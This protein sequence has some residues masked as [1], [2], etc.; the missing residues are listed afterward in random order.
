[1]LD[2]VAGLGDSHWGYHPLLK[3][4]ESKLYPKGL[5]PNAFD[6]SV[7]KLN[8]G[9]VVTLGE[10]VSQS[11][12]II[13]RGTCVSKATLDSEDVIVKWSW[14]AKTRM[15][16]A[17]LVKRATEFASRLD[18]SLVLNHLP[19]LLHCEEREF[20]DDSPQQYLSHHF[21]EGY[22]LRVLRIVVQEKLYPITDLTTAAEPGEAFRGIFRCYRWLY[23]KADIM[24]RDI[25]LN[26]LMYRRINGKVYG[27]LN[28][29]DLSVVM[30]TEPLSTSK[31]RTGTEPY[32]ARDLL[33]IGTPP[34]H[35]YRF[36]LESLFY[37]MV[38][39]LCQYHDGKMIDAPPFEVGEHLGTEALLK[40]KQS[41]F[42]AP[43]PPPTSNFLSLN[44]LMGSL[45]F[46]LNEAYTARNAAIMFHQDIDDHTLGGR[47]NFDKFQAILEANLPP[48][49]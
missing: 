40:E 30:G 27:V 6:G 1:M 16:K 8:D 35:L 24:H 17:Q 47:V 3:A 5:L 42:S 22:E 44:T 38:W 28:D 29:F 23:E 26:N 18:D 12:G 32:M 36:D 19:K 39:V 14:P 46:M 11:H 43:L 49:M 7:I 31:Q 2:G 45:Y 41:F 4:P 25:S 10:T 48:S 20:N 34:P 15:A 21:V 9:R 33:V 13:G 37:V